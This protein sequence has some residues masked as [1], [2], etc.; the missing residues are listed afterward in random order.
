MHTIEPFYSWRNLYIASNDKSSPFFNREYNAMECTNVIYD[1][2]I[3][4]QWDNIGSLTLFIKILFADYENSFCVIEMMGEW[5]DVLHNDIM[6]FKRNI[7]EYLIENGINKFIIIGEN[8]LNFH[9]GDDDYYIEWV[10][11]IEDG[12]IVGLN[13]RDHV[14]REFVDANLDYYIGFGGKF[15]DFNWRGFAPHQLANKIDEMIIKR[16]NP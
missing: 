16:L 12:W 1:H 11:E 8:I 2:Y 14:I 10:D 3:H 9:S 6:H 13:F 15:N 4:P 5:N 7:I